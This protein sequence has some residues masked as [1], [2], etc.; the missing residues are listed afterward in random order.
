VARVARLQREG[1][2]LDLETHLTRSWS[3]LGT[4][5]MSHFLPAYDGVCTCIADHREENGGWSGFAQ[6]RQRPGCN[7]Y[8]VV[9]IAPPLAAGSGAH[10]A[11][12]RL[13]AHLAVQAGQRGGQRLYAGVP[14][15]SEEYQIF[16]HVGFTAYAQEDVFQFTDNNND[17]LPQVPAL[18]LRRQRERDSWGLQ[19]LYATVTP[20]AVQT[21]EGS[22][23]GEWELHPR[24][25]PAAQQRRGYVWEAGG[26]INAVLQI[27]T[28]GGVH[29]IRSLLH[30]DML[31]QGTALVSAALASVKHPAG[32]KVFWA[33]RTYEAGMAETLHGCGFQPIARQTLVVKHCTVRAREP[34]VQPVGALNG[35]AERAAH[36]IKYND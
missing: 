10:A 20:R 33:V 27:R 15:E 29:W 18:P 30:P 9:L 12:Q 3:P 6:M 23:Q 35:K 1:V 28:R 26:D 14:E 4:A 17:Q 16:R 7:E 2:P 34:V 25:W 22:G 36:T 8:V 11:W 31:D 5:V 13:L 32:Q 24:H 19:R 21:A